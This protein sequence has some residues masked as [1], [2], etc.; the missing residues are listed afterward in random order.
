M[1]L[2]TFGSFGDVHPYIA[3]AIELK[4]RGHRPLLVT[5]EIYREKIESEGIDF[6]PMRPDLPSKDDPEQVAEMVRKVMDTEKG[7]EFLIK[8]LLMPAL[9]AGYEDLSRATE[10][11]DLLLTHPITYA[12]PLVAEKKELPWA[13]SVL[14]PASFFSAYDPMVPPTMPWLIKLRALGPLPFKAFKALVNRMTKGWMEPV[15]SLRAELSLPPAPNPI[16]EG[17][18]SPSLVLAL[19]SSLLGEPQADWP[20]QT[21]VTGFPFYDRRDETVEGQGLSPEL[22]EFLDAGPLPVIFTLGSSAIWV[23]GDF[24]RESINAAK[25]LGQRALLLLGGERNKLAGELPEG[26]AA[27]EYAPYGKLLPRASV[28]VHQGG[29]GTTGQALRAGRPML[30]VPFNHDQPDNAMRVTRLGVARTI[31]RND[32][33]SARVER[34]LSLLLNEKS[35]AERAAA[36]GQQVQSEN[37]AGA[38]ADALEGL[39]VQTVRRTDEGE[40]SYAAGH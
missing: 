36:V 16:F 14:A 38:A 27:F 21:R 23:A 5:S 9:R 37:G 28:I 1:V 33:K 6:A 39:L 4:S 10:G 8:D 17:Q 2:T 32:Y 13:S 20:P 12:G 7:I 19:F 15:A 18:H 25:A 3:I 29:V 22:Q 11:A 40:L 26:I 35:Y 31:T 30:V 24:Y 34:E